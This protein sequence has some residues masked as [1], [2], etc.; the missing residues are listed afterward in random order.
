MLQIKN[1]VPI[2]FTGVETSGLSLDEQAVT[3]EDELVGAYTERHYL[4]EESAIYSKL[5]QALAE[6]HQHVR[7]NQDT[8][9]M[10]GNF[11]FKLTPDNQL[12]LLL[13][14]QIKTERPL[15]VLN[16]N[17]KMNICLQQEQ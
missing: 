4:D 17:L 1:R 7:R 15:I 10:S 6:I 5:Q 2:S 8:G 11:Y 16:S 13:A 14:T 9:I 12:V 3:M